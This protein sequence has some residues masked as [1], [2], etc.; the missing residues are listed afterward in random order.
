MTVEHPTWSMSIGDNG[1]GIIMM[2]CPGT[3][4][5]D[6]ENTVSQ[7]KEQGV[8][9]I[10]SMMTDEEMKNLNADN[11]STVCQQNDI[12][13]FNMETDDH[14]V[15][16][17]DSLSKWEQ[18]KGN[19][20]DVINQGGKV[21]VHCKGGTGRTGVGV[22]MLLLE[23]GKDGDQAVADVKALKPGAFNSDLTVEFIKKRAETLKDNS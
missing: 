9:A 6:V 18:Y 7:L 22:A 8:I 2:P 11:L 20:V 14:K 21:A 17:E 19:L 5:V 3:K 13:W 10:L 12:Q 15:P 16:G 1:A 23:L 4:E